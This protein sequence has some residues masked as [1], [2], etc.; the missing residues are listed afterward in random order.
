MTLSIGL[1]F[2]QFGGMPLPWWQQT[3]WFFTGGAVLA[4]VEL[5][6]GLMLARR[7]ERQMVAHVYFAA[8]DLISA[9][10]TSEAPNARRALATAT[11]AALDASDGARARLVAAIAVTLYADGETPPQE[12]VTAICRVGERIA[13]GADLNVDIAF[14]TPTKGLR[15]LAVA[16]TRQ[17][18]HPEVSV[19]LLTYLRIMINRGMVANG[20]RIGLCM[21][22]ATTVA[23]CVHAPTYSFW[24]PLTVATIVRP[25]Y[26]TIFARTVNRLFGTLIGASVVAGILWWFPSGIVP[27]IGA[28]VAI[29]FAT[30]IAPK[31]YGLA[32]VGITATSL[33]AISIGQSDPVSPEVRL[34]DTVIGAVIAVV[35]GYVMWPSAW[36]LPSAAR[37]DTALAA[38]RAFLG[39]VVEPGA[40]RR[41]R[42]RLGNEA[43]R[44]THQLRSSA[45]AAV[46]EPPPVNSLALQTV[47][48]AI[49]LEEII[50]SISALALTIEA[51]EDARGRIAAIER[52]LSAVG[53]M[54]PS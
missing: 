26:S 17:D 6:P 41:H 53:S 34:L 23:V 30:A 50:D 19:P 9:I 16:L 47:T 31:S 28:A 7:L 36:R 44:L 3:A 2:G 11:A 27:A 15:A 25:Q 54:S 14:D 51:G 10:G 43:Y 18:W 42:R 40:P 4:A 45:E 52:R 24:I 22:V 35:F 8:A 12:V 48:V 37:L 46:D 38:V 39:V 32:V 1:A 5:A 49:E 29:A 33:L 13:V 21:A 20:L